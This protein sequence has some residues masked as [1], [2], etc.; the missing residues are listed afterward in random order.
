VPPRTLANI[1][2]NGISIARD[3]NRRRPALGIPAVSTPDTRYAESTSMNGIE[4]L[5]EIYV[6]S[7][8]RWKLVGICTLAGLL[9][10]IL[11]GRALSPQYSMTM[12][13]ATAQS[14]QADSALS[15]G[16]SALGLGGAASMLGLKVGGGGEQ[17]KSYLTLFQSDVIAGDFLKNP[18]NARLLYQDRITADGRW[19]LSA[20]KRVKAVLWGIFGLPISKRPSAD[21]AALL[22]NQKIT[23]T[24][25]SDT[26][27]D[28]KLRCVEDIRGVCLKL[29][30]TLH[31]LVEERLREAL[32]DRAHQSLKYMRIAITNETNMDT[33]AALGEMIGGAQ[34]Q[35]AIYSGTQPVGATIVQYP[36][37]PFN[38][39]FPKP[40]LMMLLGLVAGFGFGGLI[41][42]F[43]G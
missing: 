4:L 43:R 23:V 37:E 8:A 1:P 35:I 3:I 27:T 39:D 28:A 7:L 41:A 6:R 2:R 16:I 25:D 34:K 24:T 9:F 40:L 22:I 5:R 11:V 36:V 33:R 10:S 13:V 38:P 32:L 26:A 20:G 17:F 19:R 30:L 14:S 15:S 42:W 18:A 31:S 12:I 29:L 21:E